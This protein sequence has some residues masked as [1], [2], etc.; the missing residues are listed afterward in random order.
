MKW[1]TDDVWYKADYTGY[2]GLAEYMVS[3]VLKSSNLDEEEYVDY[4]T[5]EIRYGFQT[6]RGCKSKNF[7]PQSWQ[8]ITL[9]R[10]FQQFHGHGLNQSIY[11]I[12][13]HENRLRF[14]VEQVERITG[15][16][17]FGPYMCKLLTVDA[18]FLNEDRHTHNIAV[19]LDP[20]GE[21]HYC[22]LFDHGAALL[23]DTT[24]DYPLGVEVE[25][26]MKNVQ[27]KTFCSDF[28]EQL[29]IAEKLY[30]Q[31][32]SFTFSEK[33]IDEMLNAD[34]VYPQEI[35]TRVKDIVLAQR[36]KYQYLFGA[37][38]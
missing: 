29:D 3:G 27:A 36:R 25:R 26:L 9:E 10:L 17:R 19:L 1:L 33:T 34:S 12:V 20:A 2:E 38:V 15:L 37:E 24:M 35:K 22:P 14:L 11:R 8:M 16:E 6:F 4:C 7:L 23:A 30:G 21:Y 13:D 31:Q 28:D 5:E 18:F 32:V